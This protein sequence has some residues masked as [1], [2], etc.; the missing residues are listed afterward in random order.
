MLHILEMRPCLHQTVRAC[1]GASAD[2]IAGE[3]RRSRIAQAGR[4]GVFMCCV[5]R[6]RGAVKR[7]PRG[8]PSPGRLNNQATSDPP[9]GSSLPNRN[10]EFSQ[11]PDRHRRSRRPPRIRMP[12]RSPSSKAGTAGDHLVDLNRRALPVLSRRALANAESEIDSTSGAGG[13]STILTV[14]VFACP[15]R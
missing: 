7:T 10:L 2:V 5:R 6:N 13:S 8:R 9:L 3:L 14:A 15:S 12:G 4:Q 11:R 1:V